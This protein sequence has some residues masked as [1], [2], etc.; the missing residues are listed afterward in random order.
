MIYRGAL[1]SF[2]NVETRVAQEIILKGLYLKLIY[3][4]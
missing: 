4:L 2:M 3:I 1:N